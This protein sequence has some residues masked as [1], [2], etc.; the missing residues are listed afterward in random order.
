MIFV[1]LSAEET[2]FVAQ[3]M[4]LLQAVAIDN[5]EWDEAEHWQTLLAKLWEAAKTERPLER[6]ANPKEIIPALPGGARQ[7]R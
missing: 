2:R 5:E 3:G 6:S 1:P 4:R 7:D